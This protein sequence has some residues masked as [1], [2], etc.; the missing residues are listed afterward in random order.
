MLAA[1]FQD[2]IREVQKESERVQKPK[3]AVLRLDQSAARPA[4]HYSIQTF[5]SKE[6]AKEL[7]RKQMAQV[8]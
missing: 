2:N 3:A 5:N 4:H 6:Q 8:C 7:L 1:F